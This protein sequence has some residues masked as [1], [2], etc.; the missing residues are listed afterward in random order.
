MCEDAAAF[1]GKVLFVCAAGLKDPHND[2]D[3]DWPSAYSRDFDFVIAVGATDGA[4]KPVDPD[5]N[6]Y[7]QINIFAPG[8]AI[9]SAMPTYA[10]DPCTDEYGIT[11]NSGDANY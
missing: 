5:L 9:Y 6:D 11:H 1:P 2:V 4:D 3:I 7:G 8:I 10:R